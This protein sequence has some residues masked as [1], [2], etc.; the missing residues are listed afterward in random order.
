[1]T[2]RGVLELDGLAGYGWPSTGS[3]AVQVVGRPGR[4]TDGTGAVVPPAATTLAAS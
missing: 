1:M 4:T 2:S 3:P